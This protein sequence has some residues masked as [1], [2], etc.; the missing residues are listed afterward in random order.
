MRWSTRIAALA[1]AGIL[2]V[3]SGQAQAAPDKHTV[4][5]RPATGPATGKVPVT[6]R[7]QPLGAPRGYRLVHTRN[8]T[9]ADGVQTF[10]EV[11]CP[12]RTVIYGGGVFVESF[13]LEANINSSYPSGTSG[14]IGDVNNAS[15]ADTT[16]RVYA[17][18]AHRPRTGYSIV[19]SP[20]V[21]NFANR[22]DGETVIC[23]VHSKVLG[24]GVVSLSG[25]TS[26]NMNST[27]PNSRRAWHVDVNNAT[28]TDTAMQAYA[29]CGKV[30]GYA[31]VAGSSVTNPPLDQTSASVSCP[32]AT[33]PL[34][35]GITSDSANTSVNLNT[36]YPNAGGVAGWG[37]YENNGS[38]LKRSV[39][40]FAICAGT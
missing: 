39:T 35:G 37:G 32:G 9:A 27:F 33:V 30:N 12:A 5:G 20:V 10:G 29:V 14:W 6:S 21:P 8:L 23:P 38:M 31:R 25:S 40:P 7:V 24:G 26:V 4:A 3:G 11:N 1:V 17:V 15:G 13:S 2:V 36:T 19:S 22:Q 18:C 28:G 16:F 34:G